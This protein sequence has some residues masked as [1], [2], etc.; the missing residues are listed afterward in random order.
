MDLP[1]LKDKVAIV[2]GAA[3]GIGSAAARLFAENGATV[4]GL[5][6]EPGETVY[7]QI[8][9][10]RHDEVRS[11]IEDVQ[12]EF[13]RVDILFNVAGGSGRRWGDGPV[14]E[15]SEEAWNHVMDM[16]LKSVFLCCK[17]VISG[18]LGRRSGSIINLSSVLGLV[19]GDADFATHAYAAAKGA[20]ISLTK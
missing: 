1:P 17:Y 4:C 20:I 14:H 10:T 6:L 15:C 5:D 9:L 3:G 8:D 18:M 7:A 19:G 12:Q 11:A 13:G 16:N 2:T